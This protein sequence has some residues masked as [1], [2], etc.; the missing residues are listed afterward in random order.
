MPPWGWAGR[1][2]DV[3]LGFPAFFNPRWRRLIGKTARK[4]DA[5]VIIVRDIPL[6]LTAIS[7]GRLL[8]IPIILDMA[9]HYPA[10]IRAIWDAHRQRS[11]DWLVRNPAV[12]EM[13]ER[14]CIRGVDHIFTVADEMTERLA[15]SGV[16]RSRISRVGNTPPLRPRRKPRN[17]PSGEPIQL[18]Y[19]G[20][21]EVARGIE[22]LIDAVALLHGS[23]LRVTLRLI[24]NGRDEQL[25]RDHAANAGLSGDEVVFTGYVPYGRAVELLANADI[26][27]LPL[28]RNAHMD[29]TVPNKLFDYMSVGL[30]VITSDAIP[31]ARIVQAEHAGLVFKAQSVTDLACAIRSLRNPAT[32]LEMGMNGRIAVD[33][34]YNWERDSAILV[35]AV[36]HT[37]SRR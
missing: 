4:I 34:I 17:K 13:V 18:V 31:S 36:G 20:L 1:R 30:P 29:T 16:D 19:L 6:C 2:L 9:E 27:M 11:L 10:M 14:R 22:E 33:R 24:G 32:R 15:R 37:A 5:D 7:V 21:L 26:G 3:A 23:D 25:F 28:R 8:Q 35:Q 12:V